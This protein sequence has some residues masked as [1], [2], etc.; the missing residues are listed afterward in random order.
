M[1]ALPWT[2]G[3]TA[4]PE[5]HILPSLPLSPATHPA[6]HRQARSESTSPGL[7][8]KMQPMEEE[9]L[10]KARSQPSLAFEKPNATRS[11][12]NAMH[13]ATTTPVQRQPAQDIFSLQQQGCREA[14]ARRSVFQAYQLKTSSRKNELGSLG[15][16][17]HP[18][19]HRN[20]H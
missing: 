9:R 16:R 13:A 8:P 12:P 19:S 18:Q 5:Q 20:T 17:H 4:S 2:E 11:V 6:S 1:P 3:P 15:V 10:S 14:N 7:S